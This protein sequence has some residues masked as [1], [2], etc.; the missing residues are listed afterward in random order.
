MVATDPLSQLIGLVLSAPLEPMGINLHVGVQ[1]MAAVPAQVMELGTRRGLRRAS[2]ARWA[3]QARGRTPRAPAAMETWDPLNPVGAGSAKCAVALISLVSRA[4]VAC[5][6]EW[7]AYASPARCRVRR[8]R[9][10]RLQ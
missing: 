7:T 10:V 8:G 4:T 3:F 1:V 5:L 2:T 9:A 6:A